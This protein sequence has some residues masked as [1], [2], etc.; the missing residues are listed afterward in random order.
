MFKKVKKTIVKIDGMSCVH[1]KM[2]VTS[3]L[4]KL[5]GV[6]KV[7]V[8]LSK[9]EAVIYSKN[10]ISEKLIKEVIEDL[11]YKVVGVIS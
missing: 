8:N 11:D 2:K 6:D 1:C 4:E 5:D 3:T 9:K 10:E 7:K